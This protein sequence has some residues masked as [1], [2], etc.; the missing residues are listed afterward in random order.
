[1]RPKLIIFDMDGT[2]YDLNDVVAQNYM[3]QVDFMMQETGMT[4]ADVI[5]LFEKN[6]VYPIMRP[7][8]KSCT[9]LMLRMG[10]DKEKW[11]IYREQNFD[12]ESIDATKAVSGKLL[13]DFHELSALVLL[14]SN[15]R[16]NIQR[17]LWKLGIDESLFIE[18]VCSDNFSNDTIFNKKDA[19]RYLADKY[20]I[21]YA[22]ILSIGDRYQTDVVPL[23][24][25]GGHGIVLLEPLSLE[26]VIE[27]LCSNSLQS[28]N[29]YK[30]Y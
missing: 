6:S 17:V 23:L 2:L 24:D 11:S 27:D 8:S 28:N 25:L 4:R 20:C 1:M 13:R 15:S 22:E 21:N 5:N 12:I 3:M 16:K 18:I 14:S 9:E 30:Y 29:K 19:M 7:D 26:C 10:L